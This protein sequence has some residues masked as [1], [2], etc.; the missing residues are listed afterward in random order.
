VA[1]ISTKNVL[2]FWIYNNKDRDFSVILNKNIIIKVRAYSWKRVVLVKGTSDF[3]AA[4]PNPSDISLQFDT[5]NYDY[6]KYNGAG[7]PVYERE[8]Y[9]DSIYAYEKDPAPSISANATN[10]TINTP[11]TIPGGVVT[12]DK[13]V[14]LVAIYKLYNPDNQIVMTGKNNQFTPGK[15]G[16]YQ[17]VYTAKDSDGNQ[18][19]YEKEFIVR[20]AIKPNEIEAF[21]D[22]FC[23]VGI[24][25]TGANVSYNTDKKFTKNNTDGS[26]KIV[27]PKGTE[28]TWPF[29]LVK[30]KVANISGSDIVSFWM[31][32]NTASDTFVILNSNVIVKVPANSWK[33]S[34]FIKGTSDYNAL[35]ANP[36]DISIK[37][38]VWNYDYDKYFGK[39][40]QLFSREVYIDEIYMSNVVPKK[41]NEIESFDDSSRLANIYRQGTIFA[42]FN[43]DAAFTK[44]N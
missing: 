42:D 24:T 36:S 31:Y 1:D 26:L 41:T 34:E 8:I 10:G 13:D 2:S 43:A 27:I 29:A 22:E 11:Y 12:D 40:T 4:F 32:N 17:I 33:Y 18:G 25:N 9:I 7:T 37:F 19:Y 5:W 28:A 23:M 16:K 20:D 14:N 39:N 21:D 30:P 6:D 3:I 38:D 35:F 15:R 44:N